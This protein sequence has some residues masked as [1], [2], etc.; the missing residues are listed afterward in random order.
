M[1]DRTPAPPPT[2]IQIQY[3]L[4][5]ERGRRPRNEDYAGIWLGTPGQQATQGIVAAVADG[6]GGSKGGRVAAELAVRSFIDAYYAQP[7]TMGVQHAAATSIDAFN[8]WLHKLGRTD[9][10]LE[11]AACTFTALILLGRKAHVFHVGDSRAYRL[12]DS[13]LTLLTEDHTLK[14]PDL[15]HVLFRAVGIEPFVRLDHVAEPLRPHDRFLLCSDGVHGVLGKRRIR[16]LLLRRSAP[17]EAAKEIVASR[18]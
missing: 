1:A 17:E 6:V 12:S 4:A 14:Q 7:A 18:P 8:R 15:N 11:N 2:R 16:D 13:Q 5:S 10:L 9:A 3:G